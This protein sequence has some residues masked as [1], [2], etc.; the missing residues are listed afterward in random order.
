MAMPLIMP[1]EHEPIKDGAAGFA[2]II[3]S[4]I[5]FNSKK[6]IRY[7]GAFDSIFIFDKQIGEMAPTV[8]SVA[9]FVGQTRSTADKFATSQRN[10]A[11]TLMILYF[12]RVLSGWL[13]WP[14]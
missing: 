14:T 12:G 1:V 5:W 3:S 7:I 10:K 2:K 8:E 13:R 6:P 4:K 9:V 11:E